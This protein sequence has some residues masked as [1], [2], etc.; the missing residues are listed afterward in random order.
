MVMFDVKDNEVLIVGIGIVFVAI[1]IAAVMLTTVGESLRMPQLSS[2][3]YGLIAFLVVV[4]VIVLV[5]W[6][7]VT[8][9]G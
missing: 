9:K 2:T 6:V 5:V 8:L 1:A 4:A 3:G 7:L